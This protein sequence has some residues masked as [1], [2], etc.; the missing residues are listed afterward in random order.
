MST[1]KVW[2]WTLNR[3][4]GNANAFAG[5]WRASGPLAIALLFRVFAILRL[6]T[7]EVI[8]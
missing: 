8:D 5:A 3:E 7:D 2:M 1:E 6:R 4:E